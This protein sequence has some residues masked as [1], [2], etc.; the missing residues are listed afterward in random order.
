M[1]HR[2]ISQDN[3]RGAVTNLSKNVFQ[4]FSSLTSLWVRRT[5]HCCAVRLSVFVVSYYSTVTTFLVKT[6][7]KWLCYTWWL[8][9]ACLMTSR[10]MHAC[11]AWRPKCWRRPP[12]AGVEG[13]PLKQVLNYMYINSCHVWQA[14]MYLQVFNEDWSHHSASNCFSGPGV[15]SISV[16]ISRERE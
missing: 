11:H 5:W 3:L 4:N 16:S 6:S 10:C 7:C 9:V 8:H 15:T 1:C 14:Y 13:G 2:Y 12:E